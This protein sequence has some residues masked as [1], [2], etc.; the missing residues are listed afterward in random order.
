MSTATGLKETEGRWEPPVS[1]P[2]NEAVWQAWIAKGRA[3]DRRGLETRAAAVKWGAIV[4]L[5]AVAG[6]WSQLAP[7]G[8]AVRFGICAAAV[9]VMFKEI[10]ERQYAFAALFAVLALLFVPFA[11]VLSLFG[12]WQRALVAASAVPFVASIGWRNTKVASHA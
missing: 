10:G 11:P 6:L 1:P 9:F 8:I 7:Y 12:D 4:L 5:V 3:G 2:L